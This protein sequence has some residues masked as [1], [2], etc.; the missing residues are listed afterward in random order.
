[1]VFLAKFAFDKEDI[2]TVEIKFSGLEDS[3]GLIKE[4]NNQYM[5]IEAI[6]EEEKCRKRIYS[7]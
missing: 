1:M 6:S 3:I 4:I 7:V 5:V 2:I